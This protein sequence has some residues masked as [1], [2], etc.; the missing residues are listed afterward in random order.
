MSKNSMQELWEKRQ[1]LYRVYDMQGIRAWKAKDLLVLYELFEEY[2][3]DI[4]SGNDTNIVDML[5][6]IKEDI[7]KRIKQATKDKDFQTKALLTKKLDKVLT[8]IALVEAGNKEGLARLTSM[9]RLLKRYPSLRDMLQDIV[10]GNVNGNENGNDNNNNNNNNNNNLE[11]LL[12]EI[13]EELEK[14]IVEL[15]KQSVE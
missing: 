1:M 7:N 14:E 4:L 3:L 13:R 12:D 15:K 9:Y 10:N 11:T 8:L 6:K 5:M 2:N